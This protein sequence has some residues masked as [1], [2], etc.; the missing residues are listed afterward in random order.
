M[1]IQ[2]NTRLFALF[3]SLLLLPVLTACSG[4][5][6]Q[7]ASTNKTYTP[8]VEYNLYKKPQPG[9]HTRWMT[10][11]NP[12]GEKGAGG[13]VNKG[14]KGR[15]WIQIAPGETVTLFDYQGAGIINHIWMAG[16]VSRSPY[17][18]QSHKIEMFWDGAE[19]PAVSAP[20]GDFFGTALGEL[21]PFES[22]LFVSP[23]G[24]SMNSFVPM[25]FHKR[26][27]VEITNGSKFHS[28][29]WYEIK[30]LQV[31]SLPEDT[32]YFHAY[33]N[34]EPKT[35]GEGDYVILPKVQGVGR[36]L[37]TNIGLIGNPEL[38]NKHSWFGEGEVKVYLDG[39]TDLPTLVGTGTEDY[40]GTG[41]GQKVFD[42]A[43]F[44]SAVS[45]KNLET[46]E[47][48]Y[49]FYRYHIADPVYFHQDIKVTIQTY[50]AMAYREIAKL[51]AAGANLRI[52]SVLDPHKQNILALDKAVDFYN[53][54]D[55]EGGL[56]ALSDEVKARLRG[57]Y[58]WRKG[59]DVSATAYFYLDK[60]SSS[61][62]RFNDTALSALGIPVRPVKKVKTA[63]IQQ[64]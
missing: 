22:A 23:E 47:D 58:Y 13:T 56:D 46:K 48:R 24:K 12:N 27:R 8:G 31:D 30:L 63:G 34:R 53:L 16:G 51:N 39:D 52:G 59:D 42:N 37:G 20:L 21:K 18:R 10:G 25:P 29:L 7:Q 54:N 38:M 14:A 26:G 43:Y 2:L 44:G 6:Q 55:I 41:W 15:A 33:W 57:A 49:A 61:L 40:I 60:P 45:V 64:E 11:E 36:Y 1:N 19:K 3:T 4:A 28:M 17:L 5:N 50:G 32:M 35:T 9:M 62:P